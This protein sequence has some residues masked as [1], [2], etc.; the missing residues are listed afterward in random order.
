MKLR[1]RIQY[2]DSPGAV[3]ATMFR[4]LPIDRHPKVPTLIGSVALHSILMVLFATLSHYFVRIDD[5]EIDKRQYRLETLRLHVPDPIYFRAG[6][7]SRI[8]APPSKKDARSSGKNGETGSTLSRRRIP[9]PSQI[10]LPEGPHLRADLPA[11]VEPDPRPQLSP[12]V[13]APSLAFWARKVSEPPKPRANSE[14]VV[15]GR[16]ETPSA[17][18]KLGATPVIAVPNREKAAGDINVSLPRPA[19]AAMPAMALPNSATIPVRLRDVPEAQAATF[20]AQAGQPVNVMLLANQRRYTQEVEIPKGL[21][22]FPE[23]S[24]GG[25]PGLANPE[26]GPGASERKAASDVVRPPAPNR[27]AASAEGS[28]GAEGTP[29]AGHQSASAQLALESTPASHTARASSPEATR[30]QHPVNGSFDVVIQSGNHADLADV[31]QV[32]TGNPVYTVYLRV[33]DQKEWLLQYCVPARQNSRPNPY[34]V[35]VDDGG[36]TVPP[37]PITTTVPNSILN[38]S[39]AKQIV[40]RGFLTAAGFLRSISAPES[41]PFTAELLTLLSE[42]RFR[43]AL[44][45]QKPVEVEVLLIIPA[46]G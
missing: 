32:L 42:W 7:K 35:N 41:T 45:S 28:R 25:R 46:R 2:P 8:P 22:N 31:G 21:Q 38:G 4:T 36:A 27:V 11:I 20:D 19:V 5:D 13:T 39:F 33:G 9:V 18:P 43:P 44:S 40:I 3:A 24:A 12:A 37:Y 1:I 15:P 34:E 26:A 17:P 14:A 29:S 6:S 23:A 10:Q 30:I 16:S